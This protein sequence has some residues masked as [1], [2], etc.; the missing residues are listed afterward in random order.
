MIKEELNKV[1][2]LQETAGNPFIVIHKPRAKESIVEFDSDTAA[3][4]IVGN[5]LVFDF[6]E[7]EGFTIALNRIK[8]VVTETIDNMTIILLR[9]KYGK[10]IM[11]HFLK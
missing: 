2:D 8:E 11:L 9:L 3:F 1:I 10:T 7:L 6:W 5:D 4:D